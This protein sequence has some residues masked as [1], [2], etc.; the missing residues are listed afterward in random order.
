ME[1][2]KMSENEKFECYILYPHYKVFIELI[3]ILAKNEDGSKEIIYEDTS[4]SEHY[5]TLLH[6]CV[7][8]TLFMR[9]GEKQDLMFGDSLVVGCKG[10]ILDS[11][12]PKY[13]VLLCHWKNNSSY[14][15]VRTLGLE[16]YYFM[17]KGNSFLQVEKSELPKE[18]VLPY[19]VLTLEQLGL[20]DDEQAVLLG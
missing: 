18:D 19:G 5:L 13:H 1:V 10:E 6:D 7:L 16:I 11:N 15:A 2:L 9:K 3:I 8:I 20:S 14:L 4:V 17:R 12:L